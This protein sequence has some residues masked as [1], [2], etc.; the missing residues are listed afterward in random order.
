[1]TNG[2]CDHFIRVIINNL[3]LILPKQPKILN[4]NTQNSYF[5]SMNLTC[6]SY[7][8]AKQVLSVFGHTRKKITGRKLLRA[9]MELATDKWD[10]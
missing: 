8:F 6:L 9:C 4:N 10:M 5:A 1:M 7:K 2:P 3:T